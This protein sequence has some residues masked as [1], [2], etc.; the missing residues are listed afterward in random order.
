M[1]WTPVLLNETNPSV[2]RP[3]AKFWLWNQHPR[4]KF[5]SL[6]HDQSLHLETDIKFWRPRLKFSYPN[7]SFETFAAAEPRTPWLAMPPVFVQFAHYWEMLRTVVRHLF[8][9]YSSSSLWSFVVIYMF[10]DFLH[11]R[12]SG[13]SEHSFIS[14]CL[15][16]HYFLQCYLCSCCITVT[17]WRSQD[18][19]KRCEA[20]KR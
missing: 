3:R 17:G 6:G 5:W 18:R 9:S 14:R 8:L 13:V 4:L 1:V 7:Q 19:A 10:T 12:C 16:G 11:T 20:E 2:L 15:N